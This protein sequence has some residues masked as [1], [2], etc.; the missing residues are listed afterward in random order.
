MVHRST[1]YERAHSVTSHFALASVFFFAPQRRAGPSPGH[2][3]VPSECDLRDALHGNSRGSG[4]AGCGEQ[5]LGRP[6]KGSFKTRKSPQNVS[7]EP[8]SRC[9]VEPA[10][11]QLQVVLKV[12]R[13]FRAFATVFSSCGDSCVLCGSAWVSRF[14]DLG[15]ASRS[16]ARPLS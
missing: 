3:V 9:A 10:R 12:Q 13:R 8:I 5:G 11:E 2:G 15:I 16:L 6:L 14:W 1:S 7:N 4:R